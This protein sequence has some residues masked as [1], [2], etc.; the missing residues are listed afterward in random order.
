[1]GA[2]GAVDRF[3]L[4]IKIIDSKQSL[5]VQVHP[6]DRDV[7]SVGGEA[8]TEMWY[9]LAADSGARVF[10]GL[11]SGVDRQQF[12]VAIADERA[13]EL[14]SSV[15][16]KAGDAIYIPGGRVHAIDSGC[17]LLEVQQNSNTTYRVFDWGRL[18]NDGKPRP[19]HIEEALKVIDWNDAESALVTPGEPMGANGSTVAEIVSCPY[20]KV[21]RLEI[22]SLSEVHNDGQSFHAYFTTSGS[23]TVDTGE[24]V[25]RTGPGASCLIAAC[26]SNYTLLPEDGAAQM[27]RVSTP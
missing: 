26:V 9:V 22:S 4:L 2:S 7:D 18:G 21:E 6:H 20:F 17:L 24:G 19:L 3:P 11:K 27:I 12:E 10:A 25:E 16:V 23:V 8:K 1:L 13:D 15:P 14:L 5:S